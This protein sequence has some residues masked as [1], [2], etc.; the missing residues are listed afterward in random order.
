K[1][2]IALGY[3]VVF[4]I[5]LNTCICFLMYHHIDR[6]LRHTVSDTNI[7]TFSQ[8]ATALAAFNLERTQFKPFDE[9]VY[10]GPDRPEDF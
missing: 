8:S 10:V 1:K 3:N 9:T 4:C 2:L 5:L 6:I 7:E